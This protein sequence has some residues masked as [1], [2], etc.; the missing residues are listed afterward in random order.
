LDGKKERVM[1]KQKL[2][3][4]RG[5]R[6]TGSLQ[7][8]A[9]TRKG[10]AESEKK[11]KEAEL[12]LLTLNTQSHTRYLKRDIGVRGKEGPVKVA[13]SVGAVKKGVSQPE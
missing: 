8:R 2:G 13:R 4:N 6:K 7:D 10:R 11:K 1:S 5:P 3:K 9:S 12:T